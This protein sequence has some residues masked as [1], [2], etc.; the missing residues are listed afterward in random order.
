MR[1]DAAGLSRRALGTTVREADGQDND[2]GGSRED[3]HHRAG[4]AAAD[5]PAVACRM[6]TD[7]E[8]T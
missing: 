7:I 5:S 3:P 6:M 2:G 8:Q 4:H 1:A